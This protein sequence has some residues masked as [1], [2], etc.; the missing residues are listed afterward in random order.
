MYEDF[1]EHRVFDAYWQQKGWYTEGSWSQIKDVPIFFISGWYDYFAEGLIQNF[2]GLSKLHRTPK[3]LWLGPWPHSVGRSECGMV[4]FGTSANYDVREVALDWFDQI[5]KSDP[6]ELITQDRVRYFRMGGGDG[7]SNESGKRNHGGGWMTSSAWPPPAAANTS[8]FLHS[9]LGLSVDRPESGTTLS[10]DHDPSDPVPS[11]GGRYTMVPTIPQCA[12]DQ[13]PLKSRGD[14]L[15]F[16]TARLSAPLDVTGKAA[17]RLWVSTDVESADFTAKL[18]DVSPDGFELVLVDNLIRIT[19]PPMRTRE[20]RIELGSISNL[21]GAG[22]RI[23]LEVASSNFPR[24]ETNP[25][26]ARNTI[27]IGG[28]QASALELPLMRS[29]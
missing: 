3:K 14:I 15:R 13:S 21:F 1:Y 18:V 25:V 19:G 5:L 12:Q 2:N 6:L 27:H 17:A 23:R 22:H 9:S 8:Y 26:K 10:W 24:A 28:S 7:S 16:E 29:R 11:I 20:V 4:S